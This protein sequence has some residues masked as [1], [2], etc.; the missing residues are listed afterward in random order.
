MHMLQFDVL[1]REFAMHSL[2]DQIHQHQVAGGGGSCVEEDRTSAHY[3]CEL[4]ELDE[5]SYESGAHQRKEEQALLMSGVGQ[6]G[7]TVSQTTAES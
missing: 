2:H 3:C 4:I 5:Y 7:E 6:M 1:L